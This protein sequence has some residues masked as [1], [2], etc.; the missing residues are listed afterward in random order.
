MALGVA[1]VTAP[2]IAFATGGRFYL[3]RKPRAEWQ[4][5]TEITCSICEHPFEP[6]DMAYCPAYA[7]PICSLCCS[8]DARCHDLCKPKARFSA[9]MASAG[10]AALPERLRRRIDAKVGHYIGG[11]AL[12]AGVISVVLSLIYYQAILASPDDTDVIAKALWAAFFVL[13]IVAGVSTWFFVLAQESRR[14]AQEES[15][16]QTQLL[17]KEIEAHRRTDAA[18]QKP[19]KW[20]KRR[21]W[22]RAGMS[23]A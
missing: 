22:P 11:L 17:L 18:L 6:E 4:T 21:V 3:A 9:Q 7:A 14:V 16:R 8:L 5:R 10:K 1:L 23:S 19:R 20:P 2:I 15:A 12:L 13:M